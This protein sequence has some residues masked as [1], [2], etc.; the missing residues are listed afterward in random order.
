MST[1]SQCALCGKHAVLIDSH[2]LPKALYRL[3]RDSGLPNP[4]FVRISLTKI[5]KDGPSSTVL[6][7]EVD[8]F[9]GIF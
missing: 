3:I 8:F 9:Y 4:Q 2:L 5:V 6:E 1:T 7:V